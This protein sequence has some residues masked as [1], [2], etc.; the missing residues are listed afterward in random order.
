[1]PIS[2]QQLHSGAQQLR[3]IAKTLRLLTTQVT[4]AANFLD[5]L[6]AQQELEGLPEDL[7]SIQIDTP[8]TQTLAGSRPTTPARDPRLRF[9]PTNCR[10]CA[11]TFTH[12]EFGAEKDREA[13]HCSAHCSKN[14]PLYAESLVYQ[15][16]DAQ[17][18]K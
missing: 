18:K 6:V 2:S 17:Y 3:E 5:E 11:K 4:E 9:G 16:L 14:C 1:M 13:Q 12:P 7:E 10:C 15:N 8:E